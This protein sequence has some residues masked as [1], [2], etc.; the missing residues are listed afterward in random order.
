MHFHH[1]WNFVRVAAFCAAGTLL[2]GCA[3]GPT[4]AE[5]HAS[6]PAVAADLARIYFYREASMVGS[7]VQPSVYVNGVAVGSAV[8]GGYFYIDRP[9]GEYDISTTTEK[10][11][12]IKA[13]VQPGDVR[14]IR[15]DIGMGV[16]AGHISPTPVLPEQAA[17][18]IAKCHFL[19][20]EPKKSGSKNKKKA[21]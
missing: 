8:P 12:S 5:L 14:Y 17:G 20:G 7:A 21:A 11:E 15:L 10:T 2:A 18:E 9:A 4:F 13:T 3:S 19:T 6:E 1:A 16:V